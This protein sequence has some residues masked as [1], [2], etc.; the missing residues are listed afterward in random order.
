[1]KGELEYE[2]YYLNDE[3]VKTTKA[4]ARWRIYVYLN[5]EGEPFAVVAVDLKSEGFTKSWTVL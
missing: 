3:S 5:R 4:E 1:M 2:T